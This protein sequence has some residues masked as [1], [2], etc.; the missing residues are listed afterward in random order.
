MSG[1]FP[2]VE[3]VRAAVLPAGSPDRTA[4]TMV[5]RVTRWLMLWHLNPLAAPADPEQKKKVRTLFNEMTKSMLETGSIQD[6][7]IYA[8]ASG[9]FALWDDNGDT[10]FGLM[11]SLGTGL[12][13]MPFMT[14]DVRPVLS[15]DQAMAANERM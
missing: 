13:T 5:N 14:C 3:T 15:I 6:W 1:S 2:R 8:D 11:Q 10:E 9:G 12:M 7:G 4:Y